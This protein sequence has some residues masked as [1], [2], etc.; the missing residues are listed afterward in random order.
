MAGDAGFH[1]LD[2]NIPIRVTF[3]WINPA[4]EVFRI[5]EA[6]LD[7]THSL[8]IFGSPERIVYQLKARIKHSFGLTYSA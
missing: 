1:S 7:V 2:K 4:L 5:D 8:K 3:C 6:F